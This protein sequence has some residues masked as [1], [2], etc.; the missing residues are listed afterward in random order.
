MTPSASSRWMRF[1]HGVEDKP[2]REPISATDRAAFSCKTAS[3]LRSMASMGI[4]FRQSSKIAIYRENYSKS[5][6][7]LYGLPG[8]KRLDFGPRRG[9]GRAAEPSAFD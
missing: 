5:S 8:Q 1:Q 2:T 9:A 3:I 6:G 4:F 7:G